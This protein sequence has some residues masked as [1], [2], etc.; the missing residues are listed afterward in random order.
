MAI[1]DWDKNEIKKLALVSGKPLEVRCAEA[2]LKAGWQ[3]S[4]GTFYNDI[5]SER[6][7]ELDVLALK[8]YAFK[9]N[10]GYGGLT[11]WSLSLRVLGSCKG[12][13]PEHGPVTYS[14]SATSGSLPKPRLMSYDC[15]FSGHTFSGLM[16]HE[17]ATKFLTFAG[18]STARQ[19]VGFDIIHRKEDQ[20][21]PPQV[22]YLRKTDRDLYEGLDSA[23]KAAIFWH[24][25]ERRRGRHRIG[26]RYYQMVLN[27]PLLVTSMPFWDVSIDGGIPGEPELL[28][29]G[30]HVSLYP[31][32]DKEAA[33]EPIMSIVWEAAKLE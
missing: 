4:L 1:S 30:Y 25:E 27:I 15:C 22:D 18:L 29:S 10:D 28:S 23:L 20:R 12:F 11:P 6:I 16:S 2:F 26:H 13:A 8:Q 24:V 31:S 7:R 19:V 17:A 21:K 3:V 32:G 5:A 9:A 33:P 14:A